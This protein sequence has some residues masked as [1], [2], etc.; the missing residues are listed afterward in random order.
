MALQ[1]TDLIVSVGA[2]F[3]DRVTGSTASFAPY[4]KIV[5]MD[6]DPAA[7]SKIIKVDIPVVGDAKNVLTQL[8]KIVEP[9]KADEWNKQVS[10]WKGKKQFHY[11][12]MDGEIKPQAV[13]EELFAQTKGKAVVATEVGQHQMWAAHYYL[14]DKPRSLITSGGLGTMGYG[15]PAAMGAAL[16]VKNRPVVDIAGDGSIQ[17]NIQEL[18]TISIN[19]IPVKVI[20]LN[21]GYLGMVRQWQELFFNKRYSSTCLRQGTVCEGCTDPT[22][23]KKPY[24]PDFVALATSYNIPAFRA[25]TPGDIQAVLRKGLAVKG[26]AVMEF[27]VAQEENVFPMV[28]AGKPLHEIM[29]G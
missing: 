8:N 5:H 25:E 3:D 29:E 2:R 23:C 28:P 13:I 21:N 15:M 18:A 27:I 1:N 14:F 11:T 24:V 6:I 16:A 20:I 22:T 10:E 26:P 9:R 12:E 19:Q 7:I 17:M 4:A